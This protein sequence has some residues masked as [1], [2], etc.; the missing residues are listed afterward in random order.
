V[1]PGAL[2]GAQAVVLPL[3]AER[4]LHTVSPPLPDPP[5][6][7]Q[8]VGAS[9]DLAKKKIFPALFA[10]FYEGS[11]PE[12]RAGTL[13]CGG[14]KVKASR[15]S[16]PGRNA[17]ALTLRLCR[18]WVQDYTIVGFARSQMTQQEFRDMIA[19]T[20]TCRIDQRYALPRMRSLPSFSVWRFA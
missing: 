15:S 18:D 16:L 11:L 14:V 6:A 2:P 19:L 5:T 12:V 8:V 20:L 10:L 3:L 1:L 13:S 17:E 9:G 7:L 4:A